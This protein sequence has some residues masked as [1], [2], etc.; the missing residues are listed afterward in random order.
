MNP[1]ELTHTASEHLAALEELM[2]QIEHK[3]LVETALALTLSLV[4]KSND[5]ATCLVTYPD[6]KSEEL[7]FKVKKAPKPKT[8]QTS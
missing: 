3:F 8:R 6:G 2:P 1:V 4:E 7:R 5:G